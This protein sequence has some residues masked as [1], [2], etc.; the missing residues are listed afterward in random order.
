MNC[1]CCFLLHLYCG[2]YPELLLSHC[3]LTGGDDRDATILQIGSMER[4]LIRYMDAVFECRLQE[5]DFW[6]LENDIPSWQLPK[7]NMQKTIHWP[8]SKP[9]FESL[10]IKSLTN[11]LELG[12]E[13]KMKVPLDIWRWFIERGGLKFVLVTKMCFAICI[14][15]SA[16]ATVNEPEK[17]NREN[18]WWVP[19]GINR[20]LLGTLEVPLGA[21]GG[22]KEAPRN[23]GLGPKGAKKRGRRGRDALKAVRSY[24]ENPSKMVPFLWKKIPY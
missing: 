15:C 5:K 6:N 24:S 23:E 17:V 3:G 18:F 8:N 22:H 4:D 9:T 16:Y 11:W 10:H 14:D 19:L 13:F 2:S 7:T 12:F 20:V 1:V 21:K